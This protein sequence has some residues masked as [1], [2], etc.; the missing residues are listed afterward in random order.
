[1]LQMF[2]R[3]VKSHS[4]GLP[5]IR[6]PAASLRCSCYFI[7]DRICSKQFSKSSIHPITRKLPGKDQEVDDTTQDSK[8]SKTNQKSSWVMLKRLDKLSRQENNARKVSSSDHSKKDWSRRWKAGAE[9]TEHLDKIKAIANQRRR[10]NFSAQGDRHFGDSDF[11]GTGRRFRTKIRSEKP[12]NAEIKR[13]VEILRNQKE[14]LQIF[15]ENP[16]N[17]PGR[18]SY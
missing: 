13:C 5:T 15:S 12:N 16:Q 2:S 9:I 10:E 14:R 4:G 3:I 17:T 18:S 6:R 11:E 8:T 1:M 7:Y